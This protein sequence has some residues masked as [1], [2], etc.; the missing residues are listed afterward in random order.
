MHLLLP[1]AVALDPGCE[2]ALRPLALPHLEQL[3]ARMAPAGEDLRDEFTLSPPHERAL[4]RVLG[5][6]G[7]DGRLPW[8]ARAAAQSGADP[9]D[10]AS[11]PR[12]WVTPCHWHVAPD[13]IS[14]GHPEALGLTEIES[15]EL[16]A[17]VAPYFSEDGITLDY[18]TPTRWDARGEPLRGLASASLDRVTGRSLDLWMPEGPGARPLRRLQ[19]EMQMLLYTHPLTDARGERGLPAVNSFWLSGTGDWPAGARADAP[20]LQV[21][22][23]LRQAALHGDWAAWAA[24]WQALDAGPCAELLARLDR[25]GTQEDPRLTLCGERGALEFRATAPGLLDRWK[26]RL[27]LAPRRRLQ[28]LAGRL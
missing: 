19:S 24:A 28:D 4:A 26:R 2:A 6:D 5:L 13:H 11:T 10:L 15:R 14:M 1:Y 22:D 18:A 23:T 12:G 25:P 27:G 9:A 16:L 17:V 20:G 7:A 3:L 8:A 21:P